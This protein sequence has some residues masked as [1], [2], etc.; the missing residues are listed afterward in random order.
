M[1]KEKYDPISKE[2]WIEMIEFSLICGC[3]MAWVIYWYS[4]F[5]MGLT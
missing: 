2:E 1:S 4:I 5:M 3:F